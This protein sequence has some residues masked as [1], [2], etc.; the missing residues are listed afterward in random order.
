VCTAPPP[1]HSHKKL[2]IKTKYK[3]Y[4]VV[5]PVILG[6]LHFEIFI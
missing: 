4:R 6:Y 3:K 5:I 2:K 1:P